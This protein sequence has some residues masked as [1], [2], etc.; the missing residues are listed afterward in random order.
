MNVIHDKK[1]REQVASFEVLK[2][3]KEDSKGDVV[4]LHNFGAPLTR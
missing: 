3:I 1:T 4:K 2:D